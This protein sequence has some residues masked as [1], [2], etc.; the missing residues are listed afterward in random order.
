M[1]VLISVGWTTDTKATWNE[2]KSGDTTYKKGAGEKKFS[3]FA[4]RE[5]AHHF[6]LH[7]RTDC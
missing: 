5:L 2:L 1:L 6:Y 3:L 7:R 4:S